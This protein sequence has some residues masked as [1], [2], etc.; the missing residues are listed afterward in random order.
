MGMSEPKPPTFIYTMYITWILFGILYTP[1][2]PF[3]DLDIFSGTCKFDDQLLLTY[4][5]T[6]VFKYFLVII[7]LIKK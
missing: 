7:L 1:S 2:H 5:R 6:V 4:I 3:H